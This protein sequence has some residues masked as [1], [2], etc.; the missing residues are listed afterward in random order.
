M[1][2][3]T[4]PLTEVHDGCDAAALPNQHVHICMLRL[5]TSLN[6]SFSTLCD[7]YFFD[8]AGAAMF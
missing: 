2:W 7:K 4:T 6:A 1:P 8:T 5:L 3:Q